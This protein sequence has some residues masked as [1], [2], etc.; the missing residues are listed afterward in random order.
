MIKLLLEI[1]SILG[2]KPLHCVPFSWAPTLSLSLSIPTI[3]TEAQ[4]DIDEPQSDTAHARLDE[5][6]LNNKSM[7]SYAH[8]PYLISGMVYSGVP[9][10]GFLT[11]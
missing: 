11:A 4:R 2:A 3:I 9:P 6:P 7:V 10:I 8:F 1:M 5:S